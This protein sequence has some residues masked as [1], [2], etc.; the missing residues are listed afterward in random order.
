MNFLGGLKAELAA[1]WFLSL[2]QTLP[3]TLKP[4]TLAPKTNKTNKTPKTHKTPMILFYFYPY[5]TIYYLL[6]TFT[7]SRT[8]KDLFINQLAANSAFSRY[9]WDL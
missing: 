7:P 2:R 3:L 6:F 1:T 4:P 9:S 5:D 8:T